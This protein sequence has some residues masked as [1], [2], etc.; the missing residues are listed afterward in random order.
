MGQKQTI[1]KKFN[2]SLEWDE[3][4]NETRMKKY[5]VDKL[6]KYFP[7]IKYHKIYQNSADISI[8]MKY[9]YSII[10]ILK[11]NGYIVT[12]EWIDK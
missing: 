7:C 8:P 11:E 4:W 12:N 10:K 3:S 9:Y 2:V 6:P 1:Y 5:E